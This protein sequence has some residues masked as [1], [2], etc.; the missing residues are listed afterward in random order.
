MERNN[1]RLNIE[2]YYI[3][4]RIFTLNEID[5]YFEILLLTIGEPNKQFINKIQQN[6]IHFEQ[7]HIQIILNS[8]Q[9][10]VKVFRLQ[11]LNLLQ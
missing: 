5:C 4:E 6:I 7:N 10:L 11:K 9:P 8:L 2:L 1:I 3:Q